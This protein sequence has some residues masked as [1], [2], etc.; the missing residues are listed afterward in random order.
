MQIIMHLHFTDNIVLTIVY[1]QIS[2]NI[3]RIGDNITQTLTDDAFTCLNERMAV[4][5]I[6]VCSI[7]CLR[8]KWMLFGHDK[9][10]FLLPVQTGS[11]KPPQGRAKTQV[12]ELRGLGQDSHSF[13]NLASVYSV[14]YNFSHRGHSE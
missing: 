3:I 5:K 14:L 10:H 9:Y 12:K 2:P 1:K 7:V 11:N 13:V 6:R 8:R 4:D